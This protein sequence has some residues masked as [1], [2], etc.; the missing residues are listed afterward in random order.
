MAEYESRDGLRVIF[1]LVQNR[2]NE[3]C[4]F[5][6]SGLSLRQNVDANHGMRDTFLLDLGRVLK[7]AINDGSL[8][9]R[10]QE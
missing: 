4:G 9:L 7:T 5:A 8:Q 10:L 1:Q 3:D 6:H 2:Q